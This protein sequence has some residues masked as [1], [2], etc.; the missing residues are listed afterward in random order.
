MICRNAAYIYKI[1][2]LKG[3]KWLW[4]KIIGKRYGKNEQ[5]I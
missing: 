1:K 4:I 2:D 3:I 5:K